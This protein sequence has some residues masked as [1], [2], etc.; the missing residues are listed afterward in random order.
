[1][2]E[3]SAPLPEDDPR[4][5][6]YVAS[7][8]AG[9]F[10]AAHEH[11]EELWIATGRPRGGAL[12]GLIQL[13]VVLEHYRRGN[14]RGAR[15]LFARA[16]TALQRPGEAAPGWNVACV[17]QGVERLLQRERGAYPRLKPLPSAHEDR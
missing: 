1:M 7:F 15:R 10:Y 3:D 12:Q 16:R 6:D 11:L 17:V 14:L 9:R 5:A 8:N 4:F 13:A 2:P